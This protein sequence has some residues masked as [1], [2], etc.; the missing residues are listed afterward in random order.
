[1][2]MT[3]F[4]HDRSVC[5]WERLTL[6]SLSMAM[7]NLFVML[8]PNMCLSVRMHPLHLSVCENAWFLYMSVGTLDHCI[9]MFVTLYLNIC[10]SVGTFDP[11][12]CLF[13]W[14]LDSCICQWEHSTIIYLSVC[15]NT[16]PL[17]LSVCDARVCL[18]ER[19]TLTSVCLCEC[20]ILVYVGG[21]TQP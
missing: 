16:W 4:Q 7:L 17:H 2:K 9:C 14:M 5:L 8:D 20:L 21:S 1:M 15:G 11:D 12:I 18:W 6:I 10:L 13:V 19:L 3:S